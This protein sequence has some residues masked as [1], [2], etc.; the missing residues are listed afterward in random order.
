MEQLATHAAEIDEEE[1]FDLDFGHDA[2]EGTQFITF[3]LAEEDY[4]VDILKVQ[5]IINWRRLTRLP[6]VPGFIKGVLNLRGT[7]VPVVDLRLKFG[8]DERPADGRTVV[9]I[10]EVQGRI[11]GAVVDSVSDVV[12]F[13]D[14]DMRDAPAFA[15]TVQTDYI[16][17]MA[18]KGNKF[19]ILLDVDRMMTIE[20]LS[21]IDAV[22]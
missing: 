9:I 18:E 14:N 7:V 22:A 15:N 12:A 13:K 19:F 4:G 1:D 10:L 21:T 17:G 16:R 3:R 11:M 8:M 2:G 20:E 5:E 6:S